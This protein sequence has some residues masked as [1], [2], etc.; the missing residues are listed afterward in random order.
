MSTTVYLLIKMKKKTNYK[1]KEKKSNYKKTVGENV[2]VNAERR[3]KKIASVSNW[4][5]IAVSK[6]KKKKS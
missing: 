5:T 3:W 1:K 2:F 4:K 6:S